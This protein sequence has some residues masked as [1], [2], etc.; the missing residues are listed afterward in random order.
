[1]IRLTTGKP[2]HRWQFEVPDSGAY[3]LWLE[4]GAHATFELICPPPR[5]TG[6]PECAPGTAGA[7]WPVEVMLPMGPTSR[8]EAPPLQMSSGCTCD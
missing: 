8:F 2:K 1:V 3:Q 6:G 5:C 4:P 7:R